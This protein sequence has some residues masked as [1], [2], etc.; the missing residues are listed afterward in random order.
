MDPEMRL[1]RLDA[2]YVIDGANFKR[3]LRSIRSSLIRLRDFFR[4]IIA[5][6]REAARVAAERARV[7]NLVDADELMRH[8]YTLVDPDPLIIANMF[9]P[10]GRRRPNRWNR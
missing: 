1:E 6:A 10:D 4:V 5:R 3:V 7:V 9:Y 8:Y 2:M